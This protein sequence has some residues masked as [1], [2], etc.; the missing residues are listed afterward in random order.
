MV[1]GVKT[2]RDL[3][4]TVTS[5]QWRALRE[6][7]NRYGVDVESVKLL[8]PHTATVEIALDGDRM[9][10]IPG[11]TSNPDAQLLFDR[12]TEDVSAIFCD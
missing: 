11:K 6:V 4:W 8:D 5:E 9:F 3:G 10:D 1:I 12:L 7:E 2:E